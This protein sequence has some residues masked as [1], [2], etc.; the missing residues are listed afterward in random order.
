MRI[1]EIRSEKNIMQKQIAKDLNIPQNTFSQ[2]ENGQRQPDHETLLRIADYLNVKVDDILRDT[3]DPM[4]TGEKNGDFQS[5]RP[6]MIDVD[7][8]SDEDRKELDGY[9][10][11]LR[12]RAAAKKRGEG[13]KPSPASPAVYAN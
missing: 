12:F 2:Y 1:K 13:E 8:L 6:Y 10:A 5:R 9:V 3:S 11:W 7:G 4:P